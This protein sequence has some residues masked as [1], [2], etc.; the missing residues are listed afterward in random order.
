MST[1]D[2]DLI[3][4][5]QHGD[6]AATC[7]VFD[8]YYPGAVRLGMLSGLSR[9]SAQDCAQDAFAKAF[10]RRHQLRDWHFLCGFAALSSAI[11]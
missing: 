9:E 8:A 10:A 11:S 2:H 1:S 7:V 6:E 4:A 3:V 5:W